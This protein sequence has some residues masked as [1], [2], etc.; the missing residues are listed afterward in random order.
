MS[1]DFSLYLCVFFPD[2]PWTIPFLWRYKC[3][4]PGKDGLKAQARWKDRECNI[5]LIKD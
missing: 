3:I 5:T 1:L 4:P 2:P